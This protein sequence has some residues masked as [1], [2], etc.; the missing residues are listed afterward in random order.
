MKLDL[1]TPEVVAVHPTMILLEDYRQRPFAILTPGIG[2]LLA[3]DVDNPEGFMASFTWDSK[4][5]TGIKATG[6]AGEARFRL[7]F[8]DGPALEVTTPEGALDILDGGS[9]LWSNPASRRKYTSR[10]LRVKSR[11]ASLLG[12]LFQESKTPMN[13]HLVASGRQGKSRLDALFLAESTEDVLMWCGSLQAFLATF[14]RSSKQQRWR[15]AAL[16]PTGQTAYFDCPIP[17][18]LWPDLRQGRAEAEVDG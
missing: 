2:S 15:F 7:T 6:V 10:Q 12:V 1:G 8:D 17:N 9:V 18:S 3:R 4:C 5:P 11:P 16:E 14:S 13:T